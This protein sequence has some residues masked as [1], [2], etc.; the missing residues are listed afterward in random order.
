[1][2]ENY[3]QGETPKRNTTTYYQEHQAIKHGWR[4]LDLEKNDTS[5]G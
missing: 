1:M 5:A 4:Q 3:I 2:E